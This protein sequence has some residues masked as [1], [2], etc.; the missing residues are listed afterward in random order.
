MGDADELLFVTEGDYALP[1]LKP[2]R[3]RG[4]E[5]RR[6]EAHELIE[7]DA[8]SASLPRFGMKLRLRLARRVCGIMIPHTRVP[9]DRSSA[10][11]GRIAHVRRERLTSQIDVKRSSEIAAVYGAMGKA[12][13]RNRAIGRDASRYSRTARAVPACSHP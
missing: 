2:D 12:A 4:L 9:I 5:A 3:A 1:V 6:G 7:E 13:M 8:L 10:G 11:L